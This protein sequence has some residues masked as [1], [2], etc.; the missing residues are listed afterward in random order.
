VRTFRYVVADVFTDTP[1]AGN[2]VAVFTDARALDGEEMQ[3]L[4]RELNLSET[5]FVLPAEADGHARIRI[6]TPGIE[7]PFAGHPTLGTAFVLAAPMQLLE[8]RLE[9][10]MGTV[11][12]ALERERDRLVFGRMRQ[13]LPSW[14]PYAEE[15]ALL[16]ALGVE[17][18]ELPVELYDNGARHAYVA[19]SSEA[20]VASLRPDMSALSDL[21][22]VLGVNCFAGEESRWKTRMF[23]PAGGVAEDPATGSAA[24]PLAVHLARHGRIAFGEEIEISQ[25]AEVGRPSTLYARADGSA[26]QL[27]RV[28]VGGSAVVVARG[29]FRL[30]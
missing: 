29:E 10:G 20:E 17:R 11:P 16:S 25:G 2:P 1:L 15:A 9:T 24:G 21:P 3:R 4:A 8:I 14:E 27:E 26:E 30:P 7:M 5:V 6:F 13:P 12:V 23:A 18:S 28:E 19:L 22:A